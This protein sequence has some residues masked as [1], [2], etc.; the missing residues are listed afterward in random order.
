MNRYVP[1]LA[2]LLAACGAE[3]TETLPATLSFLTPTDGGTV[4]A[5]D[6]EV[7][8]VVENFD[9]VAATAKKGIRFLG[10]MPTAWAHNE[11]EPEGQIVLT[12]DGTEVGKLSDTTTTLSAVAAG[13]H[14]LDAELVYSD[15][16]ALEPAVTASI[17]FTAE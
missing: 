13:S 12:L 11:G 17:T 2:V 5:G 7:S 1:A 16:D 10:F 3:D 9:L 8:L 4:A 14:T 15:G 6:V